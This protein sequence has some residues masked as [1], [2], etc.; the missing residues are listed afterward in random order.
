MTIAFNLPF[1]SLG[2]TWEPDQAERDAA[3][4]LLVELSTRTS[5]VELADKE[6]STR[7]ALS[8]LYK[9]FDTTRGILRAKG[10]TVARNHGDGNLSFAVIAVRVLND[11]LR[12]VL[13]EWHPRLDQYEQLR[14]PTIGVSD[15]EHAWEFDDDLRQIGRASCRER[16]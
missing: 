4:E 9:L 2:G 15:W 3:W 13:S 11:V 6:G 14:P 16:V 1:L 8:S 5:M 12:P 10:P 7:E